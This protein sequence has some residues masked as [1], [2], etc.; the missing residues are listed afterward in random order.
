MYK[1]TII[2]IVIVI[3]ILG[4]NYFLQNFTTKTVDELTDGLAQIK[5]ELLVEDD[6]VV[7]NFK[8]FK[9]V[10]EVKYNRL[11]YFIEHDELEKVETNLVALQGYIEA[12]DL[13]AGLSELN[14][15]VFVLQHIE[16]KYA[17]NLVNIF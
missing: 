12:S 13:K 6:N 14:K 15:T 8:N 9:D 7:E 11:A 17:F 10:W 1:E 5:N 4:L 2:C 16:D 3:G